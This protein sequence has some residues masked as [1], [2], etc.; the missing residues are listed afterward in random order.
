MVLLDTHVWIWSAE[1][2][3][4][5]IGRRTRQLLSNA[6]ARETIRISPAS[7]FEVVALHTAG[8]L[9]FSLPCEQWIRERLEAAGVRLAELTPS[10]AIDAGA[11]PRAVL[12]DP[13]DRL[14]VATARQLGATLLTSDARIVEYAA[15]TRNVRVQNASR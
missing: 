1:G 12:P 6:E 15:A 4:H 8:R 13:L 5:R 11:M 10:V 9:R 7:I 3:V 2:S 14:L